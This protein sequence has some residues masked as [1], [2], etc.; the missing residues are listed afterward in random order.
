MSCKMCLSPINTISKVGVKSQTNYYD[1]VCRYCVLSANNSTELLKMEEA[2]M[3]FERTR[4]IYHSSCHV[5][6]NF[7]PFFNDIHCV[8]VYSDGVDFSFR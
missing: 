7:V 2:R 8:M 6:K 3:E 1:N 5:K 4:I